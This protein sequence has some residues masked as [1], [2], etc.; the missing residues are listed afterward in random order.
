MKTNKYSR[1]CLAQ[2][3]L[4]MKI[5]ADKRCREILYLSF[6]ASQVYNI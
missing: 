4:R 2:F 6:G 1:S 5:V 3:T